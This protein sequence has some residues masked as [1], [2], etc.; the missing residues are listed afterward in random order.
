MKRRNFIQAG[1]LG[2]T[3]AAVLACEN[4]PKVV[5]NVNSKEGLPMSIA[6]WGPN[7]TAVDAAMEVLNSGGSAL[8]SVEKGGNVP[9]GNPEDM[10][11][12]YG[13]RPDRDGKVTLDACIMDYEMNAGSVSFLQGI[14]HPLSV[15]RRVMEKTP[16]V[17]LVGEGAL[18]FAKEEGFEEEDILTEEAEKQYKEWLETAEYKPVANI[19][20]HDTI[21]ILSVDKSNNIAGACTTSGM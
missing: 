21:G 14:K 9:E 19:E 7:I 20:R 12:G 3:S 6:T 15:A 1:A 13:G 8:D 11:V 17:M 18:K 4:E 5:Q 16:H 10:S 2:L